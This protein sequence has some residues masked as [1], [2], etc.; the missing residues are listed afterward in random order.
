[1]CLIQILKRRCVL[2]LEL[3]EYGFLVRQGTIEQLQRAP[4]MQEATFLHGMIESGC[5]KTCMGGLVTAT[6]IVGGLLDA[7]PLP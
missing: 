5:V 3:G 7:Q 1:M 2:C 6:W 4:C